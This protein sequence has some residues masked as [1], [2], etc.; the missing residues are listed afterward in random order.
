MPDLP[1]PHVWFVR[2]QFDLPWWLRHPWYS[3]GYWPI[4]RQG[5]LA[6]IVYLGGFVAS[7]VAAVVVA[8]F[9]EDLAIWAIGAGVLIALILALLFSRLQARH[10]DLTFTQVEVRELRRRAKHEP[11]V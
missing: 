1:P 6:A 3:Q 9:Y 2:Y 10:G 7:I 11:S 4:T 8:V 5:W